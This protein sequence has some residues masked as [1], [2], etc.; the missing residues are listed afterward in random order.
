MHWDEQGD[1][2]V[3]F[4]RFVGTVQA[5]PGQRSVLPGKRCGGDQLR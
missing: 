4:V 2:S 1:L 5:V 3:G